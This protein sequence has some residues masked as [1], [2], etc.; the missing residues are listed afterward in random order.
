MT[1][2]F[3]A[4]R[5]ADAA[6]AEALAAA[7]RERGVAVWLDDW[8][9]VYG[10]DFVAAMERGLAESDGGL[11]L[12]TPTG[13]GTTWMYREYATLLARAVEL[14]RFLIPV[15][16][17]AASVPELIRTLHPAPADDPDGLARAVERHARR[18]RVREGTGR[19][20]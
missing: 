7:L 2:V 12:L 6:V 17:G 9:I 14:G 3:L 5:R 13:V 18:A 16:S 1:R 15:V 20:P 11:L 19:E 8:E 10:D 4:H